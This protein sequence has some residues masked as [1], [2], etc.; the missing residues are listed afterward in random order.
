MNVSDMSLMDPESI[1]SSE[2]TEK[3]NEMQTNLKRTHTAILWGKEGIAWLLRRCDYF[4]G[5]I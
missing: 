4:L 3:K 2:Q 1:Y 5:C